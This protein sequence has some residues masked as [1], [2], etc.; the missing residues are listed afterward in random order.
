MQFAQG[1]PSVA[2]EACNVLK[3]QL[4]HLVRL[5][6]DLLEVSRITR[7]KLQLRQERIEL[8]AAIRSAIEATRPLIDAAGHELTSAFRPS[9]SFSTPM[10]RGFLKSSRT[11]STTPPN[12]PKRAGTSG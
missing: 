11:C 3:R 12:M 1:Q 4:A 8:A 7:G 2:E 9:R 10:R 6:D 5:I